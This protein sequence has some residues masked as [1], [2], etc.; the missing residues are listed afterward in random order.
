MEPVRFSISIDGFWSA[1]DFVEV[2]QSIDTIYSMFGRYHSV[3]F[4]QNLVRERQASSTVSHNERSSAYRLMVVGAQYNS[5]GHINF[6]GLGEVA[7]ETRLFLEGLLFYFQKKKQ[8]AS[9]TAPTAAQ[10][11]SI[12]LENLSKRLDLL[13]RAF[14]L[15]ERRNLRDHERREIMT[16]IINSQRPLINALDQEKITNAGTEVRP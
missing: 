11:E 13:D 14:D 1:N 12:A 16:S 7:R 3:A 6:Q 9:E 15:G 4:Q 5:P 2:I 10:A 8:L